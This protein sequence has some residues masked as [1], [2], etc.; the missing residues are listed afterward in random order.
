MDCLVKKKTYCYSSAL[1][2]SDKIKYNLEL[3]FQS[4]RK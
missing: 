3:E 1:T 4:Q 2:K